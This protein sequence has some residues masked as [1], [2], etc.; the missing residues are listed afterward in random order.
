MK[1][2][3][4]HQES[5]SRGEL[6]LRSFFGVFYIMIP[7]GI[8]MYLIA[9][10]GMVV[11]FISFWAILITGKWPKGMFDYSVKM[12]RYGIRVMSRMLNLAD[13][14]P[15]FGLNGSDSNTVFD[16]EYKEEISRL[17][18]LGRT[19]FGIFLILPHVIVLYFRMIAVY[20]VVLIAWFAVLF[21][22]KYPKGMFDFVVGTV[23][24]GVRVGCYLAY[25]TDN[26][27]PFSGAAL[28]EEDG[29]LERE[30]NPEL[31]DDVV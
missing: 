18:L 24:W 25:Y 17:R 26:Y 21:T 7:H 20:V 16:M 15:E 30:S 13:G 12:Q 23:R 14:Y 27:P 9:I 4:K 28:P 1:F 3:I 8:L 22:G 2:S 29:D 19:F 10:G 11:N 31:L 6:L 5:Y